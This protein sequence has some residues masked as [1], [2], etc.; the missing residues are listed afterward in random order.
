MKPEK[1]VIV[2]GDSIIEGKSYIM[3]D[4]PMTNEDM[5]RNFGAADWRWE[6]RQKNRMRKAIGKEL[7]KL[8]KNCG[9]DGKLLAAERALKR[10][11]K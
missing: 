9:S 3:S 2:F 8:G 5:Y 10:I 7:K 1:V 6:K 11:S 4:G